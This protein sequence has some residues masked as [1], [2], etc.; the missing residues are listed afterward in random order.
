MEFAIKP[1]IVTLISL[2]IVGGFNPQPA[3]AEGQSN[4]SVVNLTV[5]PG[6]N[7]G[8]MVLTP[9]GFL[10]PL[11]GGGVNGNVVQ[12]YMGSNGGYWY[13]DRTGQTVDL[14]SYVAQVRSRTAQAQQSAPPQYAPY[15]TEQSQDSG[16]SAVG[17]AAAAGVGAMAGAAVAGLT[18]AAYYNNVPYGTPMYYANGRPYYNDDRGKNVFINEDGDV[19]WNNVYAANN[20]QNSRQQQQIDQLKSAQQQRQATQSQAPQ[21]QMAQQYRQQNTQR[22]QQQQN[23]Y[24]EQSRDRGRAQAWQQQSAGENPF[25]RDGGGGFRSAEASGGDRGGR[26]GG[27]RGSRFGNDGGG[28]FGGDHGGGFG[29]GRGG[30]RAGGGRRG[31]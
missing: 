6:N 25:V 31:R 1:L 3:A 13:V 27:D 22:F 28:R 29:G 17:T 16:G 9:R 2:S 26:L 7:G 5:Q 14:T 20:I 30:G 18:N 23:W 4:V 11:P 19:K 21:G 10:V 15:A 24:Q 8:Q 12:I